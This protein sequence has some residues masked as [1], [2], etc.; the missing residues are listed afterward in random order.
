M[1]STMYFM[2]CT[3]KKTILWEGN[4]ARSLA[5]YKSSEIYL[6]EINMV[7]VEVE[8]HSFWWL[9]RKRREKARCYLASH[10]PILIWRAQPNSVRKMNLMAF[11]LCYLHKYE[12]WPFCSVFRSPVFVDEEWHRDSR[13]RWLFWV[14]KSTRVD[15]IFAASAFCASVTL[16]KIHVRTIYE[17]WGLSFW[18]KGE[19]W[20][21]IDQLDWFTK[22]PFHFQ[23]YHWWFVPW[24]L[25][26]CYCV[27]F[28]LRKANKNEKKKE[29]DG[30]FFS[31]RCRG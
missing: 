14:P 30:R 4:S 8:G 19:L 16:W 17:I 25:P 28:D 20:N 11:M 18:R 26:I 15:K 31:Y 1:F 2:S 3:H 5:Q 23:P 7:D 6:K 24:I 21:F 12:G 10:I 22:Y 27:P 29:R 13:G 9:S